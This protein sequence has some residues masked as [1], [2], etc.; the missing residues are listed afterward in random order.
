MFGYERKGE[1]M[2]R[3]FTASYLTTH[4]RLIGRVLGTYTFALV[5]GTH[6]PADVLTDFSKHDKTIHF[7]AYFVLAVLAFAYRTARGGDF[8]KSFA[9]IIIGVVAFAAV[10]EYSQRYIPGRSPDIADWWIDNAG[11][12][13]AAAGAY[14]MHAKQVSRV[15]SR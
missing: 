7:V 3:Y 12:A 11:V 10:D 4:R 6:L 15:D 14:V 2:L 1:F 13:L 5:L 8:G 9:A